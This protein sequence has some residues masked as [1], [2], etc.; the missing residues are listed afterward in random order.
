[1]C[2]MKHACQC[3][4]FSTGVCVQV[5][6][7]TFHPKTTWRRNWPG[8]HFRSWRIRSSSLCQ[9]AETMRASSILPLRQ[10]SSTTPQDASGQSH[11][12]VSCLCACSFCLNTFLYLLFDH[13]YILET[14]SG[15]TLFLLLLFAK[16]CVTP[17]SSCFG[18]AL[19][20]DPSIWMICIVQHSVRSRNQCRSQTVL[21]FLFAYLSST[22]QD[23]WLDCYLK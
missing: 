8:R 11:L 15:R 4:W 6:C 5:S 16:A 13:I 12:S 10:T 20:I 23:S 19:F 18:S 3:C 7:G 22:M 9:G 21:H 17:A 2:K 1:M 14:C